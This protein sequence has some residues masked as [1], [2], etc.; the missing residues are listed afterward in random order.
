MKVSPVLEVI[1]VFDEFPGVVV[2]Y[3]VLGDTLDHIHQTSDTQVATL[4]ETLDQIS[5]KWNKKNI[6]Y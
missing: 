2:T 3:R 6:V 4:L 1:R 5:E